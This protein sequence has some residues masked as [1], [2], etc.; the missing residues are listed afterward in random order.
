MNVSEAP[1]LL[2]KTKDPA[3]SH[4]INSIMPSLSHPVNLISVDAIEES[5][6]EL[7]KGRDGGLEGGE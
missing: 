1:L 5:D 2:S 6:I 4:K 7:V 3:E